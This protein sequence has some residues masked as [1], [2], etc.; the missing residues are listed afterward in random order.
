VF[1]TAFA[2]L[3]ILPRRPSFA[4]HLRTLVTMRNSIKRQ[5]I[6]TTNTSD[7]VVS[8]TKCQDCW[9][10]S[11]EIGDLLQA[12]CPEAEVHDAAI[13]DQWSMMDNA[14]SNDNSFMISSK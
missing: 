10:N 11:R 9:M 5:L 2:H 7:L 14:V 1:C 13:S 3:F 4:H 6:P 12:R 8:Q